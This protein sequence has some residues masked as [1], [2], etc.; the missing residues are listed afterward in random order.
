[1]RKFIRL[2][3]IPFIFLFWITG[4]IQTLLWVIFCLFDFSDEFEPFFCP[5]FQVIRDYIKEGVSGL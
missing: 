4:I 2:F 1:M 3:A 5:L